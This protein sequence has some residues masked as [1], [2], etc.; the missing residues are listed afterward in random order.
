MG[1]RPIEWP[2]VL[3]DSA[4]GKDPRHHDSSFAQQDSELSEYSFRFHRTEGFVYQKKHLPKI[5]ANESPTYDNPQ[6]YLICTGI[7]RV[8]QGD[9]QAKRVFPTPSCNGFLQW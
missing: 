1:L 6:Q 5:L 2:M 9:P 8:R 7:F 3:V 4:F